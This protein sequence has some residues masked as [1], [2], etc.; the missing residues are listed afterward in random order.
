V[1]KWKERTGTSMRRFCWVPLLAALPG[2]KLATDEGVAPVRTAAQ[3]EVQPPFSP[4]FEPELE[5]E[6]T[7]SP[8]MPNHRQVMMTPAVVDVNQDGIPDVVFNS[9]AG[10]NYTTNGVLRAISGDDGRDLWTVTDPA[11]RVRGAASVAAGDIDGDGLVEICTIPESGQGFICFENTGAFKLR[12][13]T[14]TNDWGGPSLADLDGN[15][16]VEI[17]DGN[18]VFSSNGALLWTGSDGIGVLPGG[19]LSFA[20]DIDQDGLLEVVNGRA[21]YRHDGTLLCRNTSVAHGLAGVGNFDGDP[22]GEIAVVANGQVSLLDHDCA[23][24]WTTAIPGGGFGGAPN[25]A[26]FDGDGQAEIGVAGASRYVVYETN[27]SIRWTSPTRD[28]SSTRTG[29]STFDF[30]GDGT[31][32]VVYADEVKLRIYDGATGAVRFEVRHSSGTTY[33]NPVIVDVDADDN[34]EI[35]MIANNY[36]GFDV[37]TGIRVFRDA[38]DGW[39]N[40][41][42]IWNQHAYSVTNVNDD[43]TIPARPLTNWLQPGLN[44]FRSNSQGSGETTPFAAADLLVAEVTTACEPETGVLSLVARVRNQGDA[45]ASAGLPVA[46]YQGDPALGG[47]LLGVATVAAVLPAQGE[48]LATLALQPA[49]G[50]TAQVWAVADDDGTGAGRE[51]ECIEDNNA[52]PAELSLD[53]TDNV[54]PTAL[55]RDVTVSAGD[56]CQAA[57][58]VDDGSSDPDGQPQPLALAQAPAGPYGLGSHAV[59]LTASDGAA[60]DACTATVAVVDTTAPVLLG[61]QDILVEAPPELDGAFVDYAVSG[62]DNCDDAVAPSCDSPSGSFFEAGESTRVTCTGTDASGNAA[63]CTFSVQVEV[64]SRCAAAD[65]RAADYWRTQC[66]QLGAGQAPTDPAWTPVTLQALLDGVMPEVQATC[67]QAEST[68]AALGPDPYWDLCEQACHHYAAM[69]LNMASGLAPASCCTLEGSVREAADRV[70]AHIDA[71]QCDQAIDIAYELNRGCLF[72]QGG[73]H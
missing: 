8:T 33:E 36:H 27:G 50:G 14:P 9:F 20:A 3:C 21:V 73:E 10:G 32:E 30:E 22:Y 59:T 47:P 23:L 68:C 28:A 45:A 18:Q 48:A 39:V 66:N 4:S 51:S 64:S 58:S 49:P 57:A 53:C 1:K 13:T 40:T 54:P 37:F 29:S 56:T 69:L 5:W 52:R 71:G 38:N 19:P 61:C 43:G 7:G 25:V 26:D 62:T 70:A 2:C 42:R 11:R 34:A 35:V 31:A 63:T 60:S 17:L 12:T 72:C 6:W 41:R 24:R 46:F 65:P 67:D 15:G 44:T 55:C 16:S